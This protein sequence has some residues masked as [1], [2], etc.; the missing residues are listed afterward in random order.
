MGFRSRAPR[1]AAQCR[2]HE[3]PCTGLVAFW[4][5]FR[6]LGSQVLWFNYRAWWGDGQGSTRFCL[7]EMARR[8]CNVHTVS[9]SNNLNRSRK[10]RNTLSRVTGAMAAQ[11]APRG[12]EI[13]SAKRHGG[14]NPQYRKTRSVD[15]DRLCRPDRS[16]GF[17]SNGYTGIHRQDR[18]DKE[19]RSKAAPKRQSPQRDFC[20]HV[21]SCNWVT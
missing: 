20:L 5:A 19:E 15:R 14:V 7:W 2:G 9:N 6:A 3:R 17:A 18:R 16:W 13:V 4:S 11:T 12:L 10:T 21:S 8:I 1:C